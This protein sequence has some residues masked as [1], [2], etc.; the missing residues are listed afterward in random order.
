MLCLCNEVTF[1]IL[2]SVCSAQLML[3]EQKTHTFWQNGKF[4]TV[5]ALILTPIFYNLIEDD[6]TCKFCVGQ[7]KCLTQHTV[8]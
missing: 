8:M 1:N 6:N 4:Q 7:F 3:G 5:P 2:R